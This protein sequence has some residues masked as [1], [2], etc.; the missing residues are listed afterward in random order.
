MTIAKQRKGAAPVAYKSIDFDVKEVKADSRTIS[1]YAAV[2]NNID[3]ARDILL[4]GCFAKSIAER[5]PLSS[6]NRKIVMLNQ[7]EID[8]PIARITKLIEDEKGLYFEAELD[9]IQKADEVLTQLLSGTLNQFSIGYS[10]VWDKIE[11]DENK[12]A[13]L[14][15]EVKLYEI[16][17]VTFGCNEMSEFLGLKKQ[18][19]SV[20]S[21]VRNLQRSFEDCIGDLTEAK[22]NKLR[23]FVKKFIEANNALQQPEPPSTQSEKP[24]EAIDFSIFKN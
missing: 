22:Q 16:S 1:G 24:Q 3:D 20:E 14:V 10:Y 13:Y 2:F 21:E 6:T 7:H 17:V 18:G 23:I 5:G 8:E 4:P 19:A 12:N 15:K 9:K 11:W